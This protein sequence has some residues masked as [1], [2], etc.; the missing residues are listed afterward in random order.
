MREKIRRLIDVKSIV[1]LFLTV[2]FGGLSIMGKVSAE[3]FMTVFT[4]VVAFYFGVQYQKK[5]NEK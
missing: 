3:Q 5:E 4:T 1:T 2:V